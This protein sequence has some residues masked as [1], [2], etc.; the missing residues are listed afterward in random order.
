MEIRSNFSNN[1]YYFIFKNIIPN[2]IFYGFFI[3]KLKVFSII[4][5][6]CIYFR[7]LWLVQMQNGKSHI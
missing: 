7:S 4:F 2:V 6:E 1:K 5:L 3:Y